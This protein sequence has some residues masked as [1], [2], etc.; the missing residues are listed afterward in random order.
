MRKI[1]ISMEELKRLHLD[2]KLTVGQTAKILG[3]NGWM[4]T[5]RL[6]AMGIPHQPYHHTEETKAKIAER[7]RFRF[8]MHPENWSKTNLPE[9]KLRALYLDEKMGFYK[10]AR[11]FNCDALTVTRRLEEI[12]IP[13]RKQTEYRGKYAPIWK[14]GRRKTGDGYIKNIAPNHPKADCGGYVSEHLL[15]W[16]ENHGR[17]LPEGWVIHHLNG[18]RNDNRSCN[19]AAMSKGMHDKQ[20]DFYTKRI[21]QLEVENKELRTTLSN[22]L[23]LFQLSGVG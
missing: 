19:L 23:P 18:V 22:S 20:F 13:R 7:Q 14:G 5:R 21:R 4:V 8:S 11:I 17:S 9:D 3:C 12:G 10:I 16:E 2:E 15:V 1:E 6:R